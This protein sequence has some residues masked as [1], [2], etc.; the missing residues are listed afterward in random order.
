[1]NNQTQVRL[2]QVLLVDDESDILLTPEVLEE[3]KL[4]NQL[5]IAR[6]GQEALDFLNRCNGFEEAVRPDLILMD[7]NMPRPTS[8]RRG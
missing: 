4:G 3:C 8:S 5:H 1:M 7:I 6:D 2:I